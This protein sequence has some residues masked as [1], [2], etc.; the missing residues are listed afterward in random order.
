MRLPCIVFTYSYLPYAAQ[1]LLR[2]YPRV[3][4]LHC[5]AACPQRAARALDPAYPRWYRV[6][7]VVVV[8]ELPDL[9][10]AVLDIL[11][12]ILFGARIHVDNILARDLAP[13]LYAIVVHEADNASRPQ[14]VQLVFN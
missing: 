10:L 2:R 7:D 3:E 14:C 5:L 4:P 6:V 9:L 13:V 11:Q 1:Q 8:E 12:M